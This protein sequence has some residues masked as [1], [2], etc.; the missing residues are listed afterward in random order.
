[1]A[2]ASARKRQHGS[3]ALASSIK[4]SAQRHIINGQQ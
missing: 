2:A 1:M 4:E 3:G